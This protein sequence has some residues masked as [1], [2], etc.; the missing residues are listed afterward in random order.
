MK[1]NKTFNA[2]VIGLAIAPLAQAL[3]P[4]PLVPPDANP[5]F[6]SGSTAFRSQVFAALQ[7][8][9]LTHQP[10][11]VSGNNIFTFNG[12]PNNVT[13]GG[14]NGGLDANLTAGPVE[15]YCSFDG[16][17]QGVNECTHPAVTQN[18]EDIGAPNGAGVA[19]FTHAV[20]Y[21]F[22][23]VGQ[24][25]TIYP[26]PALNEIIS[27]GAISTG[28]DQGI[29]VQP[30]LWAANSYAAALPITSINNNEIVNLFTTGQCGLNFW[31]GNNADSATKIK[32]T[33]R[34]Y[35]SGTRITAEE[36]TPISTGTA[37]V[38]WTV[39][40]GIGTP[41]AAGNIGSWALATLG[42][43]Y[44]P[45]DGGYGS[46]GNVAKALGG[47]GSQAGFGG[48]PD[49]SPVV[50]YISFS[51][52]KGLVDPGALTAGIIPGTAL[53]YDNINPVLV[54]GGGGAFEYNIPGVVNGSYPFW[55]YE[56]FFVSA[57]AADVTSVYIN[58]DFGPGLVLAIDYE[59]SKQVLNTPQ[60][61]ILEENMDVY[62]V[63]DG[64][65]ITHF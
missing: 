48:A 22:S 63:Y 64:G 59:I 38:Q 13:L 55:S 18:F 14:Y 33:G 19:T 45:D 2:L 17:A 25:S 20:D 52:A 51:D 65:P 60:T 15:V 40:G 3:P 41:G 53:I 49:T 35:S 36:L 24:D 5:I 21:A 61:A 7:D 34:D 42:T 12:T 30:F 1:I 23:D 62:R 29:A 54:L 44:G 57:Q 6:I 46:G 50:G 8:M 37:I 58:D 10:G 43:Y 9:G 31:T 56:H 16:S 32:L 11:D 39:N 26:F 4:G 27:L 28:V 47:F